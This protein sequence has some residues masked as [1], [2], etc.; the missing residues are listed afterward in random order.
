M[1]IWPSL[2]VLFLPLLAEAAPT[3]SNRTSSIAVVGAGFAGLAAVGRLRELGFED[4]TVF[5]GS[6]HFGGRVYSIPF[7]KARLQQ[8]A[9]WVN[10][11]DN[12]IFRIAKKLGLIIGE[13]A[14][15]DVYVR[16]DI[17]TGTCTI[18]R[19]VIDEF[20]NFTDPLE[21][22]Y[23]KMGQDSVNYATALGD[24]YAK[25]YRAF[26]KKVKRRAAERNMIDALSRF[27]IGFW[28][29]EMGAFYD[30]ALSNFHFWDE[31]EDGQ[32]KSYVLNS[33]GY[34]PISEYLKSFVPDEMIKY[35]HFVKKIRYSG[36]KVEIRVQEGAKS[37][38][39]PKQFD[40]VIVTSSL[41][42]LKRY[43]RSMFEPPLPQK[44]IEAI[45]SVGYG[46]LLK[47]FLVYDKPWW[48]FNGSSIAALWVKGCSPTHPLME[49]IHTITK[50]EWDKD[51]L[52]AWVSARGTIM[53]DGV[54]DELL[55]EMITEHLRFVMEDRSIPLP[56]EMIRQHWVSNK[57][58]LGGG[59]WA[60][61]EP[62]TSK[63]F[64]A[65][66]AT[67][68]TIYQTTVGAYESGR[69]EAERI[70]NLNRA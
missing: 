44:K 38:E 11:H 35:N 61:A 12:D 36:A 28:E 21:A 64:F 26:V 54:T 55:G 23:R 24:I 13:Q 56:K 18:N 22:K 8:G 14:D 49:Y 47:V 69:R 66:E 7:D 68:P 70:A 4:I 52:V 57:L 19:S 1:R 53:I 32:A 31:G 25:D 63:I 2:C 59:Y 41:G 51:V 34:W 6:D 42:H 40:H 10:G 17:H 9:Q 65:G 27:Y 15:N 48:S 37:F 29:G 62:V 45:D 33:Q 50:L 16:A 60:M 67:H 39:Y 5:E 46:N 43:A 3:R 30:Y 20:Y 58:F